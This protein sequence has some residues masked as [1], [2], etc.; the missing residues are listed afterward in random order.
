MIEIAVQTHK[1]QEQSSS[2]HHWRAFAYRDPSSIE[3]CLNA[4]AMHDPPL[5]TA[6]LET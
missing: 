5:W 1:G 6:N 3:A 2:Q 4:Q